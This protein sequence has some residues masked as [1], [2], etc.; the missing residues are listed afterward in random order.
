MHLSLYLRD[1]SSL[2]GPNVL[3][4]VLFSNTLKPHSSIRAR[5]QALDPYGTTGRIILLYIIISTTL[6]FI[7]LHARRTVYRGK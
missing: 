7:S 4:S 6:Y 5:G 3:L 1:A 2:F